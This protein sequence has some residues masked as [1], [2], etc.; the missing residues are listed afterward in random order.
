M[1]VQTELNPRS[2]AQD[3]KLASPL[4]PRG[5]RPYPACT[6]CFATFVHNRSIMLN[7]TKDEL[8]AVCITL[9]ALSSIAVGLRLYSRKRQHVA[10]MVDDA[11]A[12][13]SLVG[14]FK[15]VKLGLLKFK[16]K[17]CLPRTVI[18]MAGIIHWSSDHSFHQ[19]VTF[20]AA[21]STSSNRPET[22]KNLYRCS[23]QDCRLSQFRLHS[24]RI[25]RKS[26]NVE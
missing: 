21:F 11:L 15:T 14:A 26:R 24:R 5:I 22:T 10:L 8:I 23:L 6:N 18:V 7:Q 2:F 19:S 16:E 1:P 12:V 4:P 20:Y 25:G 3:T 13:A 9:M 17:L